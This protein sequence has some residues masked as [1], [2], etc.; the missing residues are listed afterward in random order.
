M[1]IFTKRL[2]AV[3][4]SVIMVIMVVPVSSIIVSAE[5][6]T[7]FLGGEGTEEKPI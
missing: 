2:L 5:N 1:R 7:E 3:L 6:T 4:L